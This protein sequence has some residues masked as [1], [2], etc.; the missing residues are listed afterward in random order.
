MTLTFDGTVIVP[1]ANPDDGRRTAMALS[2]LL[3]PGS[4]AIVV[5]VIEKADGAPDKTAVE[6]SEEHAEDVFAET[7]AAL[8][9]AGGTVKTGIYY[10][11]DVIRTIFEAA[12]EHEADAVVFVPREDNRLVELLTGDL[13]RR[14]VKEA[15]VPVVALP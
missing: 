2:P 4:H 7:T 13:A 9:G 12:G 14:L 8:E 5:Y 11:E 1:A 10:G 15:T 3:E 6:Q